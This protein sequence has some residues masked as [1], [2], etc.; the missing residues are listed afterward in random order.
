MGFGQ[1]VSILN[2]AGHYLFG[3]GGEYDK[4]TLSQ[5]DLTTG[6]CLFHQ[7]FKKNYKSFHTLGNLVF[8][9]LK[10]SSNTIIDIYD[11]K[12]QSCLK[13]LTFPR[14][15][16]YPLSEYAMQIVNDSLYVTVKESLH[17]WDFSSKGLSDLP[18]S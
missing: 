8:F 9:A 13:S 5:W 18:K 11:L 1:E 12:T 15:D 7:E 3:F 6:V 16:Y 17:T 2:V 10:E 4:K 14:V